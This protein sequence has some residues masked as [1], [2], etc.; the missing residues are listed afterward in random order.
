MKRFVITFAAIFGLVALWSAGWVY[1]AHQVDDGIAAL[2]LGDPAITCASH[3][4]GGY[5]FRF[6]VTCTGATIS[7]GDIVLTLPEW[8]GTALAYQPSHILVFAKSPAHLSDAFLGSERQISW[9]NLEASLRLNGNRLERLSV[10]AD[11]FELDNALFGMSRMAATDHAEFHLVDAAAPED[12]KGRMT[13]AAYFTAKALTTSLP[14]LPPVDTSLDAYIGAMP[15]DIDL[16]TMP[17]LLAG[18]QAAGGE[19]V[20]NAIK[21]DAAD[22]SDRH[23]SATGHIGLSPQGTPEGT[24]TLNS[25]GLADIAKSM[26]PNLG[27]LIIG[28][29]EDDGSSKQVLHFDNATLHVGIVPLLTFNPLF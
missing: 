20:V 21:L 8:R 19:V 13:I 9:D 25:H 11:T 16:W 15:D 24:L 14:D 4:V 12:A 23:L 29:T 17:D 26:A 7:E 5:P 22:G 3:S 6:D 28:P 2:A 27:P 1:F 18:W 10:I